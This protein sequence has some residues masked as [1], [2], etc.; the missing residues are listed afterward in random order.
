[1]AIALV[2]A[3]LTGRAISHGLLATLNAAMLSAI[4]PAIRSRSAAL[5]AVAE[6]HPEFANA[7]ALTAHLVEAVDTPPGPLAGRAVPAIWT[8]EIV[9]LKRGNNRREAFLLAGFHVAA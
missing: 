8:A 9:H 4:F 7:F 1:M 2:R 6:P 5:G 3:R